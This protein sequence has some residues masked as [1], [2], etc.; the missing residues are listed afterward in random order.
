[1]NAEPVT[2]CCPRG[3]SL[4][5]SPRYSLRARSP[6]T[7]ACA[8]G[9]IAQTANQKPTLDGTEA[10][11]GNIGLRGLAIVAPGATFYPVGS[12]ARV[13]VVIVN[14]GAT[15]DRLTG[16]LVVVHHRVALVQQRARRHGQRRRSAGGA[17]R[18][19]AT[20]SPTE[21]RR[22][23]RRSLLQ[24]LKTRLFPANS[25]RLT[26]TFARAGSIT[27]NGAGAAV[28]THPAPR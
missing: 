3:A 17:D 19:P 8:A 23:G 27:V 10:N 16:D 13:R 22:P 1:M 28:P 11:V 14:S 24:G 9:Q 21:C 5:G 26:F 20:A 25:L 18:E 4:V 7:S 2:G 15:G 6:L 12:N